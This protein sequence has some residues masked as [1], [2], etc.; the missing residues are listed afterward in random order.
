MQ[1]LLY[2]AL[3]QAGSGGGPPS[4]SDILADDGQQ[5]LADDG[6]VLLY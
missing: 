2:L 5:F 3:L 4:D 6:E 1:A